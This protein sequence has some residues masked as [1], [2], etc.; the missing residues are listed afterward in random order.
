MV[1][2]AAAAAFV[3]AALDAAV[4]ASWTESPRVW[5]PIH[6]L[7]SVAFSAVYGSVLEGRAPSGGARLLGGA[8]SLAVPGA[9][10]PAALLLA[11]FVAAR[12]PAAGDVLA[13]FKEHVGAPGLAKGGRASGLGA[14]EAAREAEPLIDMLASPDWKTKRAALETIANLR[15][16]ALLPQLSAALDDPRP[17]IYQFA[18]SLL[19]K[20]QGEHTGEIA[21]AAE[22]VRVQSGAAQARRALSAACARY[23]DSTLADQSVYGFY[24]DMMRRELLEVV[25]LCPEDAASWGV[26]AG[27]ALRAGRF[28]ECRESY[29]KALAVSA[30]QTAARYGLAELAYALGDFQGMRRELAALGALR[31]GEPG[32][33][34]PRVAAARWWLTGP[35]AEGA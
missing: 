15:I 32:A 5:I 3:L 20:L 8:L 4:A 21:R 29:A 34:D 33:P 10:M 35:G 17:E 1:R 31:T 7:L 6:V 23:L 2:R 13:D 28:D 14:L 12:P 24:E 18:M 9:G 30:D 19:T 16:P 11:L 27:L 26:L 25:R 22:A